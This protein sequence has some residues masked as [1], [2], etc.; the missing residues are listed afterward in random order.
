MIRRPPRS[1]LTD[2]LFPY[3]T[4]FRS[5]LAASTQRI[6]RHSGDHRL[7]RLG[8]ALPAL[9]DEVFGIGL[10]IRL[11]FHLL[12]VGAGGKGLLG[13]G[14]EDAADAIVA[15]EIVQRCLEIGDQRLAKRVQR[16]R[17][18]QR[19]DAEDRKRTRLNSSP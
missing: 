15:F 16:L 19:D 12:D 13:T 11:V 6:A 1:T 5:D 7:A 18:V 10:L 4:L 17:P 14:K 3:T 2:T 8:E 9:G